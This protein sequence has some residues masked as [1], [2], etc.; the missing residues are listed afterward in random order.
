MS[1]NIVVIGG[2]ACGPKAASRA[3]RRDQEAK[4]TVIERGPFV[5]YAG[6]GLPYYIA[7]V[8]ENVEK[9]MTTVYGTV[10]DVLFFERV[11]DIK[12]MAR[13]EA[14]AIDRERKQVRIRDLE[15]GEEREI[16]YDK[17]VIATGAAPQVPPFPGMDLENVFTLRNPYQADE[18]R[19]KIEAGQADRICV[20]G[21]G[22]IGL[23]VAEALS[24]QAVDTTIIDVADQVLPG[25]LDPEM[26]LVVARALEE[27]KVVLH[28]GEKVKGFEGEGGKVTKVVTELREI[29]TDAVLVAVGVKPEVSLARE[30]GLEL[31]ET[32]AI[33]VDDEMRTSDPD[34][35]AGGDCAETKNIL[36]GEKVWIPLGSTA[37][38]Q[39]RVIGDNLTGGSSKFPGVVGTGILRTLGTNVGSTG[40]TE[41]RARELG[42]EPI[43]CLAPSG[44]KSHFY[45]GSKNILIKLVADA[46]NGKL[47]GAQVVGPGEVV[48]RVDV[49][50]A[51]ISMGGTIDDL[52]DLD[53]CYAPPFGTAIEAVAHAANILRNKRD[54]L[55][56]AASPLKLIEILDSDED[57]VVLDVRSPAELS[58]NPLIDDPRVVHIPIEELRSRLSELPADKPVMAICWVG[59]R[60][61]EASLALAG[62][63]FEQ[64][65]YVEGG[66]SVFTRLRRTD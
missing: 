7:G 19:T 4:I 48:R 6:C 37:N 13:T 33:L 58:N 45:P 36:T 11:K 1:Q 59:L 26:A 66:M 23:E 3:R 57:L 34:V 60:S 14:L 42:Y 16:G 40:V 17:L 2:V 53:L 31:G 22:R 38:R 47:L 52:A 39:G 20:I 54:G 43:S 10:R 30:A 24:N 29:E 56:N 9:L 50:A 35:F 5:S 55:A 46:K 18:I 62:A 63:G 15:T 27:E 25:S 8:V 51:V 65:V 44:D 64:A 41:K 28:L 21:A 32:G 12:V 49:A 61:Y